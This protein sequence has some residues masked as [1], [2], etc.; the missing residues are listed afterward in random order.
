ML[1]KLTLHGFKS[2]CD[3]TEVTLGS[4]ITAIVGPNGCGKS[5]LADALRWV[6]GEQNPRIL[7]SARQQDFIFSGTATRRAMGSCEVRLLF[8]SVTEDTETEI[9]RRV[10]RDGSG[11]YRLNGKVCRWKD[12]VETLAGTG[13]SHTGYVV[14]G[15][16]TIQELASGRPEDRRA[17]IEEASGVAKVR[18][19]KR[20]ME[21]RLQNAG[22]DL[23]RLDDL[24]VELVARRERLEGD[25]DAARKY[26]ELS[27]Q[28]QEIELAMWISQ[29]DDEAR[30]LSVLV[31]RLDKHQSDRRD[32]ELSL[33]RLREQEA[34]LAERK[35]PLDRAIADL[36]SDREEAAAALLALEKRRDSARGETAVLKRELETRSA[37]KA[38]L[39]RDLSNLSEEESRLEAERQGVS[40]RLS[41]AGARLKEAEARREEQE[42]LRKEY[43]EKAIAIRTEVVALT[44]ELNSCQRMRNDL[45]R[46]LD[47][48]LRA[49]TD[50]AKWLQES[51]SRVESE[52][53]EAASLSSRLKD[54]RDR[55]AGIQES[56]SSLDARLSELKSALEKELSA[57]KNLGARLSALRARKKLLEDMERAFEGYSKGPRSVLE[58]RVRGA[59]TGI[60]GSV[61]ELISC[62]AK[63]IPALSAAIGGNAENIVVEGEE[64]AK[65][66]I[67]MLRGARSGRAT[68]LPLSL[69]RPR[70]MHPRA[71][72][73][74]SRMKG[75][76]PLISVVS[77]PEPIRKI[78][79]Y[80]LG[81]VV[82]GD[83]MDTGL[84][85]MKESGWVTRVVTLSGD[86]IEPGGA[87][88][89]GEAPRSEALFRRKQELTDVTYAEKEVAGELD[90]VLARRRSLER[91]VEQKS[92]QRDRERSELAKI[93]AEISKLEDSKTRAEA[94][95]RSLEGEIRQREPEAE[96]LR[97]REK[98]LRGELEAAVAR[99]RELSSAMSQKGQELSALESRLKSSSEEDLQM[100]ADLRRLAAEKEMLERDLSNVVRR[101]EG[102][103]G[104]R[105]SHERTL[106]EEDSE[107]R[108]QSERLR[109][110]ENLVEEL[111]NE[112]SALEE[113]SA[114]LAAGLEEKVREREEI[115]SSISEC[116]AEIARIERETVSLAIRIDE[117]HAEIEA[118]KGALKD[119]RDFIA[120]EFGVEDLAT[121][122]FE[123]IARAE[124]LSQTEE[125]DALMRE[126]GSVNLKA[127]EEYKEVSDRI[128][129]ITAEKA[130][131]EE[132]ILEIRRA[133]E[134]VE[135][136]MEKRF[137]ETFNLVRSS[138]REIFRD[139]FGGGSGDLTLIEDTLGVEVSAEPPGRRQKHLNLLS[140]GERSLCGIALIF[141]I[142][143]VK[144]SPLI[145]L[146]EVDTAL[147]ESNVV[148]FGQFLKRYSRDTQ[149]MVITHQK[150]TMEAAD[151]IYGVTMQEPGVS[152]IFGMR[153]EQHASS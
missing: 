37:R 12:V 6:L 96:V 42:A 91:E 34:A 44:G 79:E 89:G 152:R 29:A 56:I 66:A 130:D 64:S 114:Q 129:L 82:L 111:G 27:R 105:S 93:S 144:A 71:E 68:F 100:S 35:L 19:D 72:Q 112:I 81:R 11:E 94:S 33:P 31:K 95:V 50:L 143:S 117:T 7:R 15:Q 38:A 47:D 21:I 127:E 49:E 133:R 122:A 2:F 141:A 106:S 60:I 23:K 30:R 98:T 41:V 43:S 142:L 73:V 146:D 87:I 115:S 57:E 8:D 132:A 107:I 84:R 74:V 25:R 101:L 40:E 51:R 16:G 147:D 4:G 65:A 59:L 99:E 62:D 118:Q 18:L 69:I 125:L 20:D 63:H 124:A 10:S 104:E 85:F 134:L 131:V 103:L 54:A 78:A 153:L 135:R 123:R 9:I 53:S 1:K 70:Q 48:N 119:T 113:K 149:F 77:F 5:N 17:W 46:R 76:R 24:M 116:Q 150:A 110:V 61:S 151:L 108:K 90:A 67:S 32:M 136:E 52:K 80:L 137:L 36:S 39:T 55:R 13:L 14:I 121:V 45:R 109:H 120:S 145:V 28:K 128:E 140:G 97:E 148:R 75:V 138:F 58:A 83:D 92:D 126:L 3:R 102:I 26:R 86:T 22:A 139:L 88:S